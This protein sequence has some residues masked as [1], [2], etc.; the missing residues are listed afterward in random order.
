MADGRGRLSSL[1]LLPE[2]AQDDILWALARLNERQRTQADILFELNDRLAVKG[3]GPISRSA[4]NRQ[5]MKMAARARRLAER[6][7]IYA[8]LAEKLTPESVAQTDLVLGEFLKTAID[9]LLDGDE[10]GSRG[11]MELARAFQATVGALK[12]SADHKAKL[13]QDA[14]AKAV[15]AVDAVADAA[16]A[17]GNPGIAA[18]DRAELHRRIREEIYGQFGPPSDDRP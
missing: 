6:Q 9:E 12:T 13:M 11:T 15:K 7:A 1:D 5:S 10:L 18:V 2:E 16:R 3:L 4:F 17:A 8:G 14:A